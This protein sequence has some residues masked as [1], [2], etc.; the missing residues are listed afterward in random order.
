MADKQK[1]TVYISEEK[2]EVTGVVGVVE[3]DDKEIVLKLNHSILTV[4]GEGLELE[5]L[6]VDNQ[7]ASVK[8]K[9]TAIRYKKSAP[10]ISFIKRLT[11]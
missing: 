11:K 5:N 7:T 4:S 3:Y 6:S 1:H 10:K 2:C 8:G 9:V